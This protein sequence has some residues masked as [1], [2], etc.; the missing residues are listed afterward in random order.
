MANGLS[1]LEALISHTAA[2][3]GFS[4]GFALKMRGW[5]EDQWAEGADRLRRRG[6]LDDSGVLTPA[7]FD[8]RSAVEDLTDRLAFEPWRTLS[9][10]DAAE[11][12]TLAKGIRERAAGLFPPGAFGPR[13]GEHR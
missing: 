8:L 1:G 13:Y 10:D 4:A 3:I 2:G 6:L 11:V 12:M 7:G 9:D 5:G